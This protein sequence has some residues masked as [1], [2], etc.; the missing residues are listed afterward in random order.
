[1]LTLDEALARLLTRASPVSSERVPLT[2]AA[3]RVLADPRIV[4]AVDVPP[5]ANSSMDGFALRAAD[6]PGVLRVAGEVAAGAE[7]L[8][9]VEPGS[10]LRIMTGAPLPPGADAVVPLEDVGESNGTV[11]VTGP[12]AAGAFVR[13]A[14][15]DTRAG[16]EV[17]VVG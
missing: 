3:A 9:P 15:H 16:D 8:A 10:A 13:A 11:S 7:T 14:A 12:V 4:A 6:V 5:F 2:D 1:M 17:G